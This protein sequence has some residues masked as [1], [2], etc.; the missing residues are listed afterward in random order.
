V[1]V[2]RSDLVFCEKML[3]VEMESGVAD[4]AAM[5]VVEMLLRRG[6]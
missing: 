3:W 5:G 4:L 1:V 2:I 6:L